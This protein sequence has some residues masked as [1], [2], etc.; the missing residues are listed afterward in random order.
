MISITWADTPDWP[1]ART[2]SRARSTA[3]AA[4]GGYPAHP[5]QTGSSTLNH[6]PARPMDLQPSDEVRSALTASEAPTA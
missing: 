1:L 2:A 4:P 3:A 5:G 6:R